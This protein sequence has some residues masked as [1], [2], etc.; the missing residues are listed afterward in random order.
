MAL[1]AQAQAI[2]DAINA[3][4]NKISTAVTDTSAAIGK[5]TQAIT[6]LAAQVASGIISPTEFQTAIQPNLDTLNAAA[7]GLETTAQALSDTATANDP[8]L[9]TPPAPPTP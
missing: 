8:A 5:A 6:D 7:D 9:Q 2:V 4:T 3:S 1:N